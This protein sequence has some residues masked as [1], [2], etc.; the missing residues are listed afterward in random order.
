MHG[1]E[2]KGSGDNVRK[3]LSSLFHEINYLVRGHLH[4]AKSETVGI[5]CEILNVPSIIGVDDYSLSLNKAANAGAV[6]FVFENGFGKT[7]EYNIK[8][9]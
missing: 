5:D 2:V 7:M 4:H 3:G 8:L 1:D 6:L 9:N